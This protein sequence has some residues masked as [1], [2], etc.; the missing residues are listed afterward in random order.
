LIAFYSTVF[1]PKNYLH[2]PQAGQTSSASNLPHNFYYCHCCCC[3]FFLWPCSGRH[4]AA[5]PT[6][7]AAAADDFGDFKWTE[8]WYPVHTLECADPSRPHAVE[9][10]GKQLVLW[11]DGQGKWQCMEDACPHR[12]EVINRVY[13]RI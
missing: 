2:K 10:L 3:C 4:Q 8:Y 12:W 9:L 5:Q 7:A 11:R 6:A 13:N 1:T